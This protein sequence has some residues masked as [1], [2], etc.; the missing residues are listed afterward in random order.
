MF[1]TLCVGAASSIEAVANHR[2]YPFSAGG[3]PIRASMAV[4]TCASTTTV[5]RWARRGQF[6]KMPTSRPTYGTFCRFRSD[7][8]QFLPETDS[9]HRDD[10]V[11][12]DSLVT[13]AQL[14]A[15]N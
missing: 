10:S 2:V 14:A 12:V 5:I 9:S 13:C 11:L 4:M 15:I 1:K 8:E 3:T 6:E 7:V